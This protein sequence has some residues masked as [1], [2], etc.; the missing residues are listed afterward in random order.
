MPLKL[1]NRTI[2]SAIQQIALRAERQDARTIS[3]SF[4]D[5]NIIRHLKNVN[6]QII[7]GRRGTGKTH[8]LQVLQNEFESEDVHCIFLIAKLQEVLAKFRMTIFLLSIGQY[9]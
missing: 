8:I 7:Q 9:S 6:H 1:Q 5:C 3:D 2:K 4:Y